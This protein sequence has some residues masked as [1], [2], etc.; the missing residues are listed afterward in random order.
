MKSWKN[1]QCEFC[2]AFFMTKYS[3]KTHR[4]TKH[5]EA[6]VKQF[7]CNY[8]DKRF[9][10]KGQVKVHERMHTKEK[11]FTCGIC[12]KGFAHRESL[13]THSTLHTGMK[14]GYIDIHISHHL[15]LNSYL[16]L[17]PYECQH[18]HSTF[19]CIGNL[20]KH[21][22]VRPDTCGLPKYTN[23]KIRNRAGVKLLDNGSQI[24]IRD[25]DPPTELLD[26]PGIQYVS[27]FGDENNLVEHQDDEMVEQIEEVEFDESEQ[28]FICKDENIEEEPIVK[29][30]VEGEIG[31]FQIEF[32]DNDDYI[33]EESEEAGENYGFEEIIEEDQMYEEEMT[34]R[35][36][37]TEK[38]QT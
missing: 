3:L 7:P 32:L 1:F 25:P 35:V 30:A 11:A 28:Q 19:S 34:G 6:G 29:E 9:A 5:I 27:A 31:D 22:K 36:K 21:R 38:L 14:V 8:C 18:C 13:V 15:I 12:N 10:S 20:I 24:I 17:Q 26:A 4:K 2:D 16:L 33:V 23:Q 37:M